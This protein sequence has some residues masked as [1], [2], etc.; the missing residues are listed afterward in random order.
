MEEGWEYEM[1]LGRERSAYVDSYM[2]EIFKELIKTFK[3]YKS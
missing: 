3:N 2:H 1:D